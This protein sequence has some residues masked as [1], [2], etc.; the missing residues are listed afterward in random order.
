MS[1][2]SVTVAPGKVWAA[3]ELVT[4]DKLN[5]AANP[6]VNLEG[7]IGSAIIADGSVT[8]AKLATG[9]LSADAT[10]LTKMA[11]GYLSANAGGRAK[12]A[13]AFVNTAKLLDGALSADS[14]GRA[15]MAA[16]FFAEDATSRALF[17]N[18]YLKARGPVVAGARNLVATLATAT[19]MTI[20]AD[21][22]VLKDANYIPVLLSG[23][24]VTIDT[25]LSNGANALDT[26]ALG[27]QWYYLWV[28]FDGTTT[29]G[30]LSGSSTAPT[31][32]GSY[33]WKALVGAVNRTG[34]AFVQ[35]YQRDREVF[36]EDLTALAAGTAVGT[37]Y[38]SLSLTGQVPPIA[39]FVSGSLGSTNNGS[40]ECLAMAAD[41]NGLGAQTANGGINTGALNGLRTGAPYR[42]L[43]K[44]A[45]TVYVKG[46]TATNTYQVKVS[47]YQI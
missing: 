17:A 21:E 24:S 31:L 18:G 44:T 1:T 7:T 42:M 36:L 29:S 6:T 43:I 38:Q 4:Y 23:V 30:L 27:N 33:T 16:G 10:G 20:T 37:S 28:I 46:T 14:T 2:I 34:A 47:G 40:S 5:L 13:D 11:D 39:K 41:A 19:T 32:P 22:L 12:M 3:D 26:G 8:T 25:G 35:F 9:V 45:S 15:K